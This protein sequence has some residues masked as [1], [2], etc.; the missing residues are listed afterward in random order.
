MTAALT[1]ARTDDEGGT[2]DPGLYRNDTEATLLDPSTDLSEAML[3]E[4]RD[5]GFLAM[6]EVISPDEV[7]AGLAGLAALAAEGRDDVDI[8]LEAFAGER[9]GDLTGDDLL[10]VV[11]KFMSFVHAEERLRAIAGHPH[12]LGPVR[13]IL[14]TDD[15]VLFQDMALLKPPGGGREKPWHQDKAFFTLSLSSP[16]VG[17]WIALDEATPENGCMHVIPGSHNEGP[18]PHVRRRDWQICDS[19]VA[20]SRDVVVPLP[21]GAALFFDGLLHHG[22][23]QNRTRT[24]RRALQ[25]HYIRTDAVRTTDDERLVVFG[26]DGADAEC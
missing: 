22:T 14:G 5:L 11:R 24:R 18:I 6:R 25:F 8:Q 1:H 16:I 15:V 13:A 26:P 23:P 19:G 10:D 21:P 4:Y 9:G 17:V 2:Y 12:V 3:A 7:D 20:T